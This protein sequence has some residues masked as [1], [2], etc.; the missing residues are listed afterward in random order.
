MEQLFS[1]ALETA[2]SL[3]IM[4]LLGCFSYMGERKGGIKNNGFTKNSFTIC[5]G[6]RKITQYFTRFY[7]VGRM[8]GKT[9][10]GT[11]TL[12]NEANNLFSIKGDYNGDFLTLPTREYLNG[13]WEIVQAKLRKYPSFRESCQDFCNLMIYG[14]SWNR[15]IYSKAVVNVRDLTPSLY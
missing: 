9:G 1:T 11:S 5:H 10:G 7:Y 15:S 3:T 13:K 12:C 8:A 2:G 6:S 14:L 4:F